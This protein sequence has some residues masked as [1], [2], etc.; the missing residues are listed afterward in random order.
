MT[1]TALAAFL[2]SPHPTM[3]NLIL[4]DEEARDVIS[5]I[6]SLRDRG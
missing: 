1:A 5:Y 4:N 3:P 6:L 2:R